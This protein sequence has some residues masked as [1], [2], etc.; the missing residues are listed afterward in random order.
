MADND[1]YSSPNLSKGDDAAQAPGYDQSGGYQQPPS[2]Y[3]TQGFPGQGYD[4][5]PIYP[6]QSYG[7]PPLPPTNA[8]W[9]AAALL[10]FWPLAFAA[11]NHSSTVFPRWSMGDYQGAQY[12]SDRTKQLGKYALWIFAAFFVVFILFYIVIIAV[13]VSVGS[14]SS[15]F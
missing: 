6:Q 15:T 13:A 14:G 4:Q 12:A 1:P 2:G 8:G 5:Q 11:F 7:P 10:F 3:S 9:A